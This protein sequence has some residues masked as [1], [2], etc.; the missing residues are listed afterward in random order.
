MVVLR[1]DRPA[2]QRL[3]AYYVC[4]DAQA[5]SESEVRRQLQAKL[6]E[7]MVPQHFVELSSIPLTPN[8]KVDR[9]A[10]PKPQT[11]G[12]SEQGYVAPRTEAEQKIAAVW[13]EV[14]NSERVGVNDDF[15]ELGGH[16]LLATQVMSRIN[17]LFNIQ[18]PLRRLFEAKT[19]GALAEYITSEKY[20]VEENPVSRI[21]R[22]SVL[23]V[24]FSQER[25]WF[26]IPVGARGYSLSHKWWDQVRGAASGGQFGA[27][28]DRDC[29][30]PR[31][32]ANDL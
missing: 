20:H 26:L 6:P 8:G 11:D 13:Q 23:S 27:K 2:D 17:R 3:T 22:D 32:L 15:F 16:S 7:Y 29:R 12:A 24:S 18:L 31:G 28:P 5:V 1:E 30:S 10:L 25:L 14:L 9:Q 21:S 4:K 19:V